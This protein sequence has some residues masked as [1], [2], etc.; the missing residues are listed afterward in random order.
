V[1]SNYSTRERASSDSSGNEILKGKIDTHCKYHAGLLTT[2][3]FHKKGSGKATGPY[4]GTFTASGNSEYDP[5]Q[6]PFY[7]FYESFA[8]T[9]VSSTITGS[10]SYAYSTYEYTSSV[11]SGTAEVHVGH[12]LSETLNGF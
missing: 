6:R 4:P 8:I 11:G 12:H 10:I 5:L 2:C 3:E 9:S 1:P 7:F